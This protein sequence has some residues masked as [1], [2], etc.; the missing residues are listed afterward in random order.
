[1]ETERD[2]QLN[3]GKH[4]NVWDRDRFDIPRDKIQDGAA[5][6][7]TDRS[8]CNTGEYP[9]CW[10]CRSG[11]DRR[12]LGHICQISN[13]PR[14]RSDPDLY[15][16]RGHDR[17]RSSS[18]R[19]ENIPSRSCSSNRY[20]LCPIRSNVFRFCS[21]RSSIHRYNWGS[22]WPDNNLCY[23]Y[24]SASHAGCH[25]CCGI[26]LYGFSSDNTAPCNKSPDNKKRKN[27]KN[28]AVEDCF[29]E[30]KDNISHR[31]NHSCGD[32]STKSHTTYRNAYGREPFQGERGNR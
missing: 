30:G 4:I 32:A 9:S 6:S 1:M 8:W 16:N 12:S 27:D 31:R 25:G 13:Q 24:I 21:Y 15:G 18:G 28:E 26:L 19:S 17:F 14:D 3:P 10:Y 23:L 7:C 11:R 22:R 29:K 20:I 5:S 2:F